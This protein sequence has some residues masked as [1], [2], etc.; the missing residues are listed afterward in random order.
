MSAFLFH[1][2]VSLLLCQA[3][4]DFALQYLDHGVNE[5]EIIDAIRRNT[6]K[7]TFTPVGLNAIFLSLF[8]PPHRALFSFPFLDGTSSPIL[9]MMAIHTQIYTYT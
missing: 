8:P 3:D 7:R 5:Q 1:V 2:F 6:I 9:L 4:D